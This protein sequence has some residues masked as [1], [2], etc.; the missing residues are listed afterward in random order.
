MQRQTKS[1]LDPMGEWPL[2]DNRVIT[3]QSFRQPEH[4]LQNARTT[5]SLQSTNLIYVNGAHAA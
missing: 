5:A 4:P 2:Q 1:G 3:L